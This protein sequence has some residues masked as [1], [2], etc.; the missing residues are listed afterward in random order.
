[1]RCA[2]WEVHALYSH[3]LLFRVLS[4]G[5]LVFA[6]QEWKKAA[7]LLVR[8]NFGQMTFCSL[9]YYVISLIGMSS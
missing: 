1:M 6:E 5:K 7:E 8:L 9:L 3:A 2:L 4:S